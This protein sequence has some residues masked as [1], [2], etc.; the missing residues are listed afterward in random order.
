[1]VH[2]DLEPVRPAGVDAGRVDGN[3][4]LLPDEMSEEFAA[5][6]FRFFVGRDGPRRGV[7][8]R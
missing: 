6:R 4:I 5:Y 1:M 8:V 3:R 7:A 2:H